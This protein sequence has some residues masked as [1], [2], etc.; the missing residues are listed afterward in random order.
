M[1][2]LSS[3]DQPPYGQKQKITQGEDLQLQGW[4][5]TSPSSCIFLIDWLKLSVKDTHELEFMPLFT[6]IIWQNKEVL[7]H[8]VGGRPMG[9]DITF[10][11]S[12]HPQRLKLL[13]L[14]SPSQST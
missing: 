8:L 13:S 12:A 3:L 2:L 10:H 6:T 14:R 9:R 5:D 1:V 7:P 11:L 4:G